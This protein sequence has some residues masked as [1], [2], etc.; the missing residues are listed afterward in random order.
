MVTIG[1]SNWKQTL[2][3]TH[4]ATTQEQFLVNARKLAQHLKAQSVPKDEIVRQIERLRLES[5]LPLDG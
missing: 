4:K 3:Q 5:G 1:N 2:R